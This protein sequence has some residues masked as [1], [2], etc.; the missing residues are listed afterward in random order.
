MNSLSWNSIRDWLASS[1]GRGCETSFIF[2]VAVLVGLSLMVFRPAS[3]GAGYGVSSGVGTVEG[4]GSGLENVIGDEDALGGTAQLESTAVLTMSSVTDLEAGSRPPVS[5][6]A[7][8]PAQP[9]LAPSSFAESQLGIERLSDL[10]QDIEAADAGGG[11]RASGRGKGMGLGVGDLENGFSRPG[12]GRVVNKGKF[13][14]WTVPADPLPFQPYFIVI[15]VAYPKTADK[16]QIRARNNDLSG[17]IVGTDNYRQSIEQTGQVIPRVSQIV[18]P[19]PGAERYVRDTITIRSKLL[20]ETQ[21][22]T[23]TF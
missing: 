4:G 14:A 7:V 10:A 17:T 22:L 2:H 8:A 20:E 21:E 5:V 18:I 19:V 15:E 3:Q 23:I 9:A 6:E 13:T 11:R 1:Y 12:S 16:K